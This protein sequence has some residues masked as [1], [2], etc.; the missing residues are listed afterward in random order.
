MSV[1]VL[2]TQAWEGGTLIVIAAFLDEDETAVTP[3]SATWTLKDSGGNVVNSREDVAIS[4]LATT[5]A[6]VLT[7]ADLDAADHPQEEL[8]LTVRF[9]YDS[10]TYGNDL[11]GYGKTKITVNPV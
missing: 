2:T 7:D 11:V 4:G 5:A 8:T 10:V 3:K 9:V 1:S 6:I